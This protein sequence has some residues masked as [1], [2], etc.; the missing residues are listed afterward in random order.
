MRPDEGDLAYVWDMRRFAL[1]V[2]DLVAG[3]TYDRF[4]REWQLRRAIERSIEIVG[5]AAN[6]VSQEYRSLHSEIPWN[7]IVAQP[8]VLAHDYGDIRDDAIWRVATL[9]IPELLDLLSPMLD[10]GEAG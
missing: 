3:V 9:R 6:R 7:A 5:E 2:Q 10:E 4:A 8:N 1:E